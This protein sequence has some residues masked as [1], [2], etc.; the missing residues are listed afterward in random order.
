M[1]GL[2]FPPD[3]MPDWLIGTVIFIFGACIGSFLNVCICRLPESRSIVTPPSACPR[4]QSSIKFYDN[5]PI[6]SYLVLLGKCR[7][8]GTRISIRYPLVELLTG[9]L[10]VAAAIRYG[11]S[12]DFIIY[13][14]FI[15][16]LVTIT[17][18]D[19]DHQIIPD[20]ISLPGIPI[21]LACSL[22]LSS[23]S[24]RDSLIGALIGGGS[25]FLV[26]WGYY[27]F[28]GKE[29]MGGGDIKLLAMIGAF[30]GWQGVFFT[31]FISSAVGSII[32]IFLM[33]VA[34][35]NMKFAVPFGPFLSLG[36]IAY[37]FFGT[38]VIF[39]YYHQAFAG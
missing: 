7:G 5:I 19:I 20:V 4:C 32:G 12:V 6:L 9:L 21:G 37:L 30:I 11:L 34:R 33:L 8:C 2:S 10:S 3:L 24:F 23:I 25:L 26:A 22:M 38:E 16:A 15:C 18:I 35:K 1:S 14:V 17:F 27:H 13:F 39:W 36:A 28:T 29:G 31:I